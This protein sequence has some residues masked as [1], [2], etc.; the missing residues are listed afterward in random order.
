MS[1]KICMKYFVTLKNYTYEFS[2]VWAVFLAA[3]KSV[4]YTGLELEI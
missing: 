3:L 4:F 2:T 1:P